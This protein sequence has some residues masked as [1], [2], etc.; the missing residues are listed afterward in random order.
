MGS[1]K[2]V[3]FFGQPKNTNKLKGM[4]AN[5]FAVLH[6]NRMANNHSIVG[7]DQ[8]LTRTSRQSLRISDP[9][10]RHLNEEF[11]VQPKGSL[12]EDVDRRI[13]QG[14]SHKKKNGEMR[15]LK[16]DAVKAVRV[17]FTGSHERMKELEE[18]QKIF[19]AWKRANYAFGCKRWG[20][21]NIVRMTLH[22]DEKTPHFHCVFV[23]LTKDGRLSAFDVLGNNES[24]RQLQNE[25]AEAMRPFG[26]ARGL[27][28]KITGRKHETVEEWRKKEAR[29]QSAAK[30]VTEGIKKSNIFNLE[31]EKKIVTRELAA[32]Y[33]RSAELETRNF[34]LEKTYKN[35]MSNRIKNSLER[36]KREVNLVQHAASMGY[37]IDRH[38]SGRKWA[39]MEKGADRVLI[40]TSPNEKGFYYYQ[41]ASDDSDRG[42]IV[43]FMLRRGSSYE[44][45]AGLSSAHLD[46]S[47]LR[48][49]EKAK[50]KKIDLEMAAE[51]ARQKY[52]TYKYEADN[53]L[54]SRGI[55]QNTSRD[56]DILTN[57]TGAIF[58]LTIS[59]QICSTI[60]YT[61][62]G[63]YFQAGLPRGVVVFGQY[64]EPKKIVITESPV[65]ALSYEQMRKEK[66]QTPCDT[67]Y[68]STCG[69][70]SG[71][72]K[73]EITRI[74]AY[75]KK[76]EVVLAFDN[77]KAGHKMAVEVDKLLE[78]RE[79]VVH[80]PSMGKDW[81]DMLAVGGKYEEIEK[82]QP[83]ELKK[84]PVQV[85]EQKKGKEKVLDRAVAAEVAQEKFAKYQETENSF[86]KRR[87]IAPETQKLADV[88]TNKRGAIF[89]VSQVDKVCSTIEY[90]SRGKYYQASLPR[91]VVVFG[92]QEKPKRIVI[93]DSP[94]DALSYEQMRKEKEQTPCDTLYVSTCGSLSRD[95]RKEVGRIAAK[96]KQAD[97]V[98]AFPE[99]EKKKTEDLTK[100]LGQRKVSVQN[101]SMGKDWNDMLGIVLRGE[102]GHRRVEYYD[103]EEERN[104]RLAREQEERL[105]R[106]RRL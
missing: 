70:L 103:E 78:S 85:Q 88:K 42:T 28:N 102:Q 22:M 84:A 94:V 44:E 19:E 32:S 49:L 64:R 51:L 100:L 34:N 31:R 77:D 104:Q 16:S 69:S 26:L 59:G 76:A 17:I 62:R 2:N 101:P 98:L 92:E 93:T 11:V 40:L 5:Q 4:R 72:I 74:A 41:S 50:D 71:E 58:S 9:K 46:E 10:R 20:K 79:K 105:R 52:T 36:V 87:D 55:K 83:S 15:K 37:A 45:I 30:Q 99:E 65:D 90:T 29:A 39:V 8:H 68:L 54:E 96:H 7:Q 23:P 6:V 14:Y 97:I 18:D 1:S 80:Q 61:P 33:T 48:Y 95:I 73:K 47:P 82:L 43:D 27:S 60:E 3:V 57:R 91:G 38:K 21:D 63:K 81:N 89:T 86:L 12:L 35:V 24:L 66:E 53:Y 13:A 106:G 67:I 75:N 56:M 25:Y